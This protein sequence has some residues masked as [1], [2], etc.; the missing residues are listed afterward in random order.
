MRRSVNPLKLKVS[1]GFR[2]Q[3]KVQHCGAALDFL[4]FCFLLFLNFKDFCLVGD[5]LN[6]FD[7]SAEG[8]FTACA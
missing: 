2:M 3:Q 6:F 4:F 8:F 5:E 7:G 1:W